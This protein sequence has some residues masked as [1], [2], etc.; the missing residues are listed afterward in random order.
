MA[1]STDHGPCHRRHEYLWCLWSI[2][3]YF[4]QSGK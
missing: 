1:L 4:N 3:N 2:H